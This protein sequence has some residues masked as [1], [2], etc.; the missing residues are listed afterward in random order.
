MEEEYKSYLIF[1]I[2]SAKYAVET[3]SIHSIIEKDMFIRVPKSPLYLK[4]AIDHNGSA[5][6]VINEFKAI[7]NTSES[8]ARECDLLILEICN[9]ENSSLVGFQIK[10]S[11]EICHFKATEVSELLCFEEK[12]IPPFVSNT[13]KSGDDVILVINPDKLITELPWMLQMSL[14][15]QDPGY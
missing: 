8:T 4:G 13:I 11:Y 7:A 15:E 6:P 14:L 3:N 12:S 9:E 2:G 1:S 5:I 10:S